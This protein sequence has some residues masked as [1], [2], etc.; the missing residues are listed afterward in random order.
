[1]R[2]EGK[3]LKVLDVNSNNIE[4]IDKHQHNSLTAENIKS[5][6]IDKENLCVGNLNSGINLFNFE[7][8]SFINYSI[9]SN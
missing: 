2:T 8:N 3:G 4:Y 9:P 1:M 7:K 5:L 6:L